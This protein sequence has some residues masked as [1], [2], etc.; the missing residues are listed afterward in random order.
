MAEHFI[1]DLHSHILFDID[2]GA[3]TIEESVE[4]LRMAAQ[5]GVRNVFCASHH[6]QA[7]LSNYDLN[8]RLLE[9][10]VKSEGIDIKLYKGMEILCE[11]DSYLPETLRDIKSGAA[12]SL[13]NTDYVL[14]EMS[15][16][17]TAWEIFECANT[18]F[19]Q[20]GKKVVL[21]HIERYSIL[22]G[23]DE[24]LQHL[25]ELGCLF[26]INAY[27][28]VKEKHD[29][30]RNFARKL[31]SEKLVDLIGSDSHRIDHRPP[32]LLSGVKFIYENC[33][34]E[35]ADAVCFGNAE[36]L[37]QNG[38]FVNSWGKELK[39]ELSIKQL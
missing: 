31:L 7:E 37:I 12:K 38:L 20:T 19:E 2:D 24:V 16:F 22:N 34:K 4:M 21:A 27:S 15:P 26:Q 36:R 29:D 14:I 10:C 6:W 33:D 18:I 1:T 17:M 32:E 9:E 28:L 30:I 11:N 23:E 25:K 35:Y 13:N 3:V 8:F 39:T 5:Q